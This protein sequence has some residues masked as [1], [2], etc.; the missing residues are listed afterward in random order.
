MKTLKVTLIAA[1]AALFS[2]TVIQQYT[3]TVDTA[4]SRLGFAV[5]HM[6][7]A[8]FNGS[9]NNFESKITGTKADFSDAVVELTADVNS[10]Y[11]GNEMRDNHLKTADFFDTEK[12]PKLTF[13]STSFT[14]VKGN[15]YKIAGDLTLH[16]VIKKVEL[17]AT[18]SG[19]AV[20]PQSKQTIDGFKITGTIKRSDFGIAPEFAAIANDVRLIADLELAKDAK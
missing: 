18:H 14:K 12:Y 17:N 7:I 9:F 3:Y 15:Q 6:G 2:F 1:V 19:S 20:H 16:G 10:I 5:T 11:T 8:D 13:K 4:H